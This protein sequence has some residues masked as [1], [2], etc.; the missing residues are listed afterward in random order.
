M[1]FFRTSDGQELPWLQQWTRHRTLLAGSDGSDTAAGPPAEARAAPAVRPEKLRIGIVEDEAIIA[2]ELED[3]LSSLGA[4]VVGIALSAEQAVRLA[5][6]E[7]PA[8]MTMDIRLQ[9]QRDGISAAI[10]IYE[11][12][13]IRCIFVS[14]YGDP[15]TVARGARARPLGWLSKP[16]RE[17]SLRAALDDFRRG[18]DRV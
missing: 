12:F 6:S 16:L 2:I 8:C 14:A 1:T 3:L 18:G 15:E 11:R 10:E 7:R 9:G 17:Q 13:G 4:E 5:E